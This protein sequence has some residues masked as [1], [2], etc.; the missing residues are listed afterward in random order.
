VGKEWGLLSRTATLALT[1]SATGFARPAQAATLNGSSRAT[2]VTPLSLVNTDTLRFGSII[3]GASAGTVTIDP[4]TEARTT[5]G[6]ITAYG[7]AIS[8]G[9]FAGLTT[10]N[11]HLKIDVPNGSV[12]LSRVGG[13]ATM[14]ASQFQINGDKNDWV[15]P[16][17]VFT[18]NVGARLNV[19]ANQMAGT[20][21]GT[22]TVTVNYR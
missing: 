22:Y 7:G 1:L 9:K 20:Y 3:P 14:T 2:I 19:G 6:G 16:A 4:F 10:A 8:A 17:T 11:S 18:F 13:G 21:T 15:T 12:T 5:T